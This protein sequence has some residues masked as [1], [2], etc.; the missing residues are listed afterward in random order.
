M[1]IRFFFE[2]E[3]SGTINTKLRNLEESKEDNRE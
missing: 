3:E 1:Q 2:R